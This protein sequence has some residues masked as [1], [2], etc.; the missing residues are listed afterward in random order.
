M[1]R[2]GI[3][4][5]YPHIEGIRNAY[6]YAND[7]L[8][9]TLRIPLADLVGERAFGMQVSTLDMSRVTQPL[10]VADRY[11]TT[12]K[13]AGFTGNTRTIDIDQVYWTRD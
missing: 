3:E 12:G 5:W 1:G 2:S 8:W 9:H 4:H 11:A 6:G 10:V 7:G 13:T